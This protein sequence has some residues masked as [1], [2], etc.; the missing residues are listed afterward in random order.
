MLN[1]FLWVEKYRPKTVDST[2]LPDELKNT[3]KEFVN[4]NNV[5]NLLLT[6]SAGVG[7]TTI[8]KAMLDELDCD[9]IVINGSNEGRSIDV[10]RVEIKNFKIQCRLVVVVSMLLSMR[11]T[12]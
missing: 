6:G 10:L 2:I 1:D 12:I 4:Q 3:F 11:L 8:A 7:K 5:T 9:Y